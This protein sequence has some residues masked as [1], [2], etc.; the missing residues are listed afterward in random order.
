MAVDF[1][2][3]YSHRH[4]GSIHGQYICRRS[5]VHPRPASAAHRLSRI[6]PYGARAGNDAVGTGQRSGRRVVFVAVHHLVHNSFGDS[7]D[8]VCN[9]GAEIQ[10]TDC[11]SAR[12]G[13]SQFCGRHFADDLHGHRT[14]RNNRAAAFV[15]ANL[16]G[17][18]GGRERHGRQS[19]RVWRGHFDADRGTINQS[20]TRPL[21]RHV[22]L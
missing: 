21:S 19:S 2:H 6:R 13:E 18:S 10:R 14:V 4:S 5:A 12:N 20:S 15:S 7:G 9:L 11:R 8:R 22:R 17:I 3:Q 1:L 16:N